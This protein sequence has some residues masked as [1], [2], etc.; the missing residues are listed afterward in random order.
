MTHG[1]LVCEMPPQALRNWRDLQCRFRAV[2]RI[3]PEL[4]GKKKGPAIARR[5]F[6]ISSQVT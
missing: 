5:A 4:A 2:H 3:Q 1:C 6:R